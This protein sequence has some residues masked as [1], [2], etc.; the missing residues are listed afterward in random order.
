MRIIYLAQSAASTEPTWGSV[1]AS[2]WAELEGGVGIICACLPTLRA[3]AVRVLR[4]TVGI[5]TADGS[6]L[7]SGPRSSRMASKGTLKRRVAVVGEADG[8]EQSSGYA[9]LDP[10]P[11]GV[12]W[13]VGARRVRTDS[14][15]QIVGIERKVEIHVLEGYGSR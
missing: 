12:R 1:S 6:R 13:S 3:P 10:R 8:E 9:Q 2:I 11:V 4:K 14:E 5:V 15:E 7:G